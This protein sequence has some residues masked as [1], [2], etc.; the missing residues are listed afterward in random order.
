MIQ[1][2]VSAWSKMRCIVGQYGIR[3]SVWRAGFDL[4]RRAGLVQSRFPVWQWADRPLDTWL[5]RPLTAGEGGVRAL[6]DK[7]SARFFFPLG[8][9]PRLKPEWAEEAVAEADR[10]LQ[11]VFRY[12]SRFEGKLGFPEPD[13]FLN[14]FTGHRDPPKRHWCACGDFESARGD[15]KFFWEPSRFSWVYALGRAYALTREER[16]A[17]AFWRLFESW[18]A[19]NPPQMGIHWQCGQEIAFRVL[20]CVFGLHVFW[21]SPA[22]TPERLAALVVLL[23][24]SAER[25]HANINY[26]R[27][28]MGNHAVNEALALFAVGTLFPALRQAERWRRC[29]QW[30]LEDEVQCHNWPDG[31]YVQHSFNYQRLALRA[32]LVALRLAELNGLPFPGG[33]CDA[34]QQ[35]ARFLYELQDQPSGRLPNYGANDGALLM[36]L[37]QCDYLDYRPLLSSLHYYYHR[38]Q[39]YAEGPW[40]EDLAWFFGPEAL[41]APRLAAPPTSQRFWEGGYYT[42]RGKRSWAMVRCHSYRSRPSQADL[43]HV[44][45]WH[46]GVNVLRDSGTFSYFDPPQDWSRYFMSSRAHNTVVVADCD[47]MVKGPRFRWF[48]VARGKTLGYWRDGEVELW[49]G[50]QYGY[51]RLVTRVTHRRALCR[52]GEGFWVIVDDLVG[53]SAEQLDLYWHLGVAEYELEGNQ[54][55]FRTDHGRGNLTVLSN[56]PAILTAAAGIDG[57]GRMGWESRYYGERTPAPTLRASMRRPLPARFVTLVSLDCEAEVTALDAC[58]S[59]A[60]KTSDDG[61][62]HRMT[63]APCGSVG[64]LIRQ[65]HVNEALAFQ[66]PPVLGEEDTVSGGPDH[67]RNR[68]TILPLGDPNVK[69]ASQWNIARESPNRSSLEGLQAACESDLPGLVRCHQAAFPNEFMTLMGR[70]FIALF[71]EFYIHQPQGICLLWRDGKTGR[72]A[73]SVAGGDPSLRAAFVSQSLGWLLASAPLQAVRHRRVRQRLAQHV[74]KGAL[75]VLRRLGAMQRW[76]P[77]AWS[78]DEMKGRWSS[79][80]SIGVDPEFRGRGIGRHLL[81]GFRWESARLGYRAMR[82]SVHD[83]NDRALALYRAAGWREITATPEGIYLA[84]SVDDL[85]CAS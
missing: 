20:A 68:Q 6:L 23:A 47:Q 29:G 53:R 54:L 66:V 30:V 39:L 85:P 21:A 10:L 28:Q 25:I 63:L 15:I 60:W 35:S 26:A 56:L 19:A 41:Q 76:V 7:S 37:S 71:Y 27:I 59:I 11:G 83:D 82:L 48:T 2:K 74:G 84:R 50:E 43:L 70:R 73:G 45:L 80:L 79:L 4:A 1:E 12:F 5:I 51:Q 77:G 61:P 16:Y 67:A 34:I 52:V 31:S 65:L 46:D 8:S 17:E 33:T 69:G 58:N 9:P 55:Q 13:W 40:S 64:S 14:P 22:T 72:V 62:D 36:P 42:L 24:A 78:P 81:E 75:G 38:Q 3:R 44:D 49:L 32:Y 18:R 57:N